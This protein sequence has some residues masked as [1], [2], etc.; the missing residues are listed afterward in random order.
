MTY[1]ANAA[2]AAQKEFADKNECPQFAPENG[3]CWNCG[4]SIYEP[5]R[6]GFGKVSGISVEEAGTNLITACPHCRAGFWY[7]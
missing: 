2:I 6:N 5:I 3:R 1:N 4:K 7:L